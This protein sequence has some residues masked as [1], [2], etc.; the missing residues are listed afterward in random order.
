MAK[1]KKTAPTKARTRKKPA[2]RNDALDADLRLKAWPNWVP[3][4]G[5]SPTTDILGRRA[6]S[7]NQLIAAFSDVVYACS[8]LIANKCAEA[9]FKL[10]VRTDP[11][12]ARTRLATKRLDYRTHRRIAETK[13]LSRGSVVEEVVDH[14]LLDML[15]EGGTYHNCHESTIYTQA[16]LEVVGNA[17]WALDIDGLTKRPQS[18]KILAPQM[19]E[20]VRDDRTKNIVAWKFGQGLDAVTYKKEHIVHFKSINLADPYSLGMSP[21]TAAWN[22]V[23]IQSKELGFLDANLTNNGRPDVILSP[24]EPIGPMEAERLA[25]DWVQRFKGQG[26]GG[27]FV[28]DGPFTVTPL[29]WPV[30]DFAE[31]NLFEVVKNSVSNVFHIP[32]DIWNTGT[33]SN[34]STKE[35]ALY[36]LAVDCIKP[37]VSYFCEKLNE[38]CKWWDDTGRLFFEAGDIVPEDKEFV[39]KEMTF[40]NQSQAVLR[41]EI[42]ERYG[43][44]PTEWGDEPLMPPG[45]ILQQQAQAQA[46]TA[47]T[48][49]PP[50]PAPV[51][52]RTAQAAAIASLQQQ[53]YSG[54]IPRQAAIAN[55]QLLFGFSAQEAE[56]LF[57]DIPP[58]PE[59]APEPPPQPPPEIS[60]TKSENPAAKTK[61]ID[62]PDIR[63]SY[64]YDCGASATQTVCAFYGV[65][66]ETEDEYVD[67]LGTTPEG[68]TPPDAIVTFLQS[69]GL[70]VEARNDLTIPDLAAAGCPV[71]VCIQAYEEEEADIPQERAGHYVVVAE[72]T[73]DI[74]TIQDPSAGRVE[75]PT[76]D[77]LARWEDTDGEGQF[78]HYGIIVR[79]TDTEAPA[80]S[81]AIRKAQ[82]KKSPKQLVDALKRF[83]KRQQEKVI[84]SVKAFD[85]G[86]V[87][88]SLPADW[89]DLADWNNVFAQEMLPTVAL[90][91]DDAAKQTVKR[92]GGSP[93]L[94]AV[95]QPNLKV[96]VERQV[97]AFA[98]STNKTTSM[99]LGEATETLKKEM[100]DGLEVGDYKNALADRVRKVFDR[101]SVERSY[102]IGHTEASRSQH[103]AMEITAINSGVCK[104]K[105][106]ILSDDAC[107]KCLPFR[108]KVV[109][110]GES[111]GTG[112]PGP[113]A[114]IKYPPAHPGCRCDCTEVID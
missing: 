98:D 94:W 8:T 15:N 50:P 18:Y 20:P 102:L 70:Q 57:P 2:A 7:P 47:A 83:F 36:S 68:G 40:L 22:R 81:K 43:F 99:E 87:T 13:R 105:K 85:D 63:Q 61:A 60:D 55:A 44:E 113:Y 5:G 66:P 17:F 75:M 65:G 90:Y 33:S 34:R 25:K 32:P 74:V 89:I 100:A 41:N 64:D 106:W 30:K 86:T 104:N 54:Q 91:Y 37:R 12:Q 14:P 4:G 28:A 95:V 84:G 46:E 92:I 111:F 77:F 51:V 82:A 96:A 114:D 1:A 67:A 76:L 38:L 49:P 9:K 103:E 23:L 6:P 108:N 79:G 59:P 39:L 97:F 107:P 24:N 21:L 26:A 109:P 42:R 110:L 72:A 16:F 58:K 35:A 69:L 45:A 101:A 29:A 78:I 88:K 11:G 52:D 112:E 56:A 73:D 93:D 10:C 80:P 3:V 53:V 48:P 27:P 31:L 62:L 19:V 71:I